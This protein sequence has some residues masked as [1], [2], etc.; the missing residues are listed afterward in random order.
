M[1]TEFLSIKEVDE[2]KEIISK[3]FNELYEEKI[4]T[5]KTKDSYNR[6][7]AKDLNAQINLPPFDKVLKDGYAIKAEDSFG[8]SEENPK[9]LKIIDSIGAGTSSKKTL[10]KGEAIEIATGAPVPNGADCLIMVEFTEKDGQDVYLLEAGTPNQNIAKKGSDIEK[11][12][13][14]LKKY[15]ELSAE[16]VGVLSANGLVDVDVIKKPVVGVISTGNE[17]LKEG[18]TFDLARIY[19]ANMNS[20][21]SAVKSCGGEAKSM[22]I[23]RD[24]YDELKSLLSKAVEET[25]IVICSG[26]T[27]A[28][29]GDVLRDVLEDLG[30]IHIHGISVKPGKPTLIGEINQ[31]LVIGLPGNPTAALIVFYVFIAK[32]IRKLTKTDSKK[33]KTKE[34]KISMRYHPPQGRLEYLLVK[35]DDDIAN[36]ILKD[37]GAITALAEADGY[38]KVGKNTEMVQEGSEVLVYLF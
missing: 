33:I 2:A 20:V 5:I 8:A 19:D 10:E 23:S 38:I 14:M 36:P 32:N 15:M 6:I 27:S 29:E 34:A 17:L 7:L 30:K 16:K 28:G 31:K 12:K 22:G 21:I 26:G 1:G 37:S 25:D 13:A 3:L 18:E 4:E 24:N 11:G 35:L 9:K